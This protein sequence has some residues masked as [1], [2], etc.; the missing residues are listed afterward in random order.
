LA[1]RD[2]DWTVFYEV[3]VI[4]NAREFHRSLITAAY[5]YMKAEQ[6]R[7]VSAPVERLL[8]DYRRSTMTEEEQEAEFDEKLNSLRRIAGK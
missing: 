6:Q 5:P 3:A 1:L 2:E 8:D 4:A 7:Q